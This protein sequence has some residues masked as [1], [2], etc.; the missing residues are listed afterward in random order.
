MHPIMPNS[1]FFNEL[2]GTPLLVVPK[3]ADFSEQTYKIG[4]FV[5]VFGSI[6]EQIVIR[7][8]RTPSS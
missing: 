7:V 6:S 4:A 2:L 1:L 3:N 8:R 5:P